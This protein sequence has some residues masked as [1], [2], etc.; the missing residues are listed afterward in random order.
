MS[1]AII[2]EI[3]LKYWL[4]VLLGL[5]VAGFGLFHKKIMAW[6]DAH[7]KQEAQVLKD[8]I[9]K[10]VRD[11]LDTLT[12]RSDENDR[13]M[14]GQM[15]ELRAGLLAIQGDAFKQKCHNLLLEE[16]HIT[17]SEFENISKDHEAYNGLGG[18]HEGDQMF[19]LVRRKFE[20]T[21]K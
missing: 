1:G 17:L 19:D 5:A 15:N 4:Q 10:E 14:R 21:L 12:E 3:V 16:H 6:R 8:S 11:A 13:I 7:K 18:N 20:N 9:V 2:L